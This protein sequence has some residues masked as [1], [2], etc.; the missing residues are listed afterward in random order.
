MKFKT[1][2]DGEKAIVI[3]RNGKKD[4]YEGPKRIFLFMEKLEKLKSYVADEKQY[5]IIKY[6]SGAVSHKRGPC[7][8]WFNRFEHESITV[9]DLY[10]L[11]SF[12]IIIVY[13]RDSETKSVNRRLIEGPCMFMPDSN[14]WIHEFNW[15]FQDP[16]NIGHL[17]KNNMKF[18]KLTKKPDFFHYY[19]KEVRTVDDTLI[20]VKLMV[21]FQ[22]DDIFKMLDRSQDPIADFINAICADVV[23]L[24]GQLTF[25]QFVQ[26]GASK[27]N[28][29]ETYEQLKNRAD[30]AG[31]TIDSVIY[32]GYTSSEALQ[33]IQD[34]A[35]HTRTKLR[36]DAEL[37]DQTNRLIDL[38]L[39]N[40]NKCMH[41]ETELNKLEVEFEQKLID[42][43]A[44]FAIN[45]SVSNHNI[46]LQLKDIENE[47][48]VEIDTKKREIEETFL[49]NLSG[50]GVDVNKYQ[51]ELTKSKSK[52]DKLYELNEQVAVD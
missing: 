42:S 52:V 33:Q 49:N 17:I 36:L 24:V 31:Y 28:Q 45:K 44:K 10:Q 51:M 19:V 50:L 46:E 9:T 47:T 1:I 5:L 41:L 11:N 43:K 7:M 37:A 48:L 27:L 6:V 12:E 26:E 40:Q 38:R 29:I 21:I 23:S 3:D 8:E 30:R 14:E 18:E 34:N 25:V 39:K 20:T 2:F 35:I 15:H 13:N 32:N 22:I 4:I 16:K